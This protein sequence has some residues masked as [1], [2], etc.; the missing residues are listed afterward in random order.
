MG[1]PAPIVYLLGPLGRYWFQSLIGFYGF[2]G[3]LDFTQERNL[4]VSIPDRVLLVFRLRIAS[5]FCPS[6]PFQSLIGFYWFSGPAK[7]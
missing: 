6:A 3:F 2:S 5:D 4:G 1:F 7:I